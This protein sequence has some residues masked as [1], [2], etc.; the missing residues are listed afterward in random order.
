MLFRIVLLLMNAGEYFDG[1]CLVISE[2]WRIFRWLLSCQSKM[3]KNILLVI[4]VLLLNAG[5]Y[6]DGYC[7]AIG[8]CWRI[9]LISCN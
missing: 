5:E 3:L 7:L 4:A 6:F 9:W 1:Y 8:E 2:C